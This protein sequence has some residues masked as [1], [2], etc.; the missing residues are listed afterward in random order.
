MFIKWNEQDKE[1]IIENARITSADRTRNE[2]FGKYT[3]AK[4]KEQKN[5][6]FLDEEDF[7]DNLVSSADQG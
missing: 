3:I 7:D 4:F 2:L 5:R 1:L 6:A